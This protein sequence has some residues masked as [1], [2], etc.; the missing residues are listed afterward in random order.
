MV[1][2]HGGVCGGLLL[3]GWA[4]VTSGCG[5]AGPP[6]R[7]VSGSVSFRGAGVPKAVVVF[8][9]PETGTYL[10]AVCDVAGRFDTAPLPGGGLP[11]GRYRVAVQPPLVEI[12]IDPERPQPMADAPGFPA[13][14][15]RLLDP[16]TSGLTLAVSEAVPAFDID[17]TPFAAS[18][19][20]PAP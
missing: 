2:R 6:C 4:V 16:A 20:A 15:P 17:L 13:V 11:E 1:S 19:A 10:S 8:D 9:Q 12:E 3:A 18:Q 14:D 5:P 7:P